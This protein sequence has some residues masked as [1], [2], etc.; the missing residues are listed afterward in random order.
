VIPKINRDQSQ[1]RNNP[2]FSLRRNEVLRM[3]GTWQLRRN[4]GR[5]FHM[6]H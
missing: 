6:D 4:T 3:K 5:E 2:V 1:V